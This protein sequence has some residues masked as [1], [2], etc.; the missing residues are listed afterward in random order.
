MA[1]DPFYALAE[2]FQF[3]ANSEAQFLKFIETQLEQY[4]ASAAI[5]ELQSLHSSMESTGTI[6]RRHIRTL[7][8]NAL[9]IEQRGTTN[10]H[11]ESVP[12]LESQSMAEDILRDFQYLL[13]RAHKPEKICMDRTTLTGNQLNS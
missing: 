9:S 8:E 10:W 5:G 6:L 4:Q 2:L 3:T 1:S 12:T 7:E 13:F 11:P